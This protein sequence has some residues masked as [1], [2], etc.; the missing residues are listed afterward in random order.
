MKPA[1]RPDRQKPLGPEQARLLQSKPPQLRY[2][3]TDLEGV[4]RRIDFYS[5]EADSTSNTESVRDLI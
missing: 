5:S 2:A 4:R 1:D 3:P